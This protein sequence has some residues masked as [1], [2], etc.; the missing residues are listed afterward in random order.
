MELIVLIY[1]NGR[2]ELLR[3]RSGGHKWY[4]L[5]LTF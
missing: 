2:Q 5:D 1:L 3:L 4:E